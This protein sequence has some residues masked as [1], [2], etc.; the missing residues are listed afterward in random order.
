MAHVGQ[1]FAF[2]AIGVL[3]R[4]LGLQELQFGPLAFGN[5]FAQLGGSLVH[6]TLEHFRAIPR[7]SHMH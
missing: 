1:K 5:F 6:A 3:R 2:Y 4:F 7:I